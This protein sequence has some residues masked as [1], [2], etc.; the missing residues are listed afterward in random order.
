MDDKTVKRW[1]CAGAV[2]AV[3]VLAVKFHM[4]TTC[5]DRGGYFTDWQ[6]VN[7]QLVIV[8]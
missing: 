8:K 5:N 2:V 4:M 3:I 6:C 1:A 7:T